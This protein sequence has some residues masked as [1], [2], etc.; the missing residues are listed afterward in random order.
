MAQ[1]DL[2]GNHTLDFQVGSS[3]KGAKAWGRASCGVAGLSTACMSP[4]LA[5]DLPAC[6][7]AV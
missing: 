5:N 3:R 2:D 1:V 4:Y 6:L 7:P